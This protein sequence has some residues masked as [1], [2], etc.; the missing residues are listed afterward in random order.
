M[1]VILTG[2]PNFLIGDMYFKILT[3]LT[4]SL[5]SQSSTE[6]HR[7]N[8]FLWSVPRSVNGILPG[9]QNP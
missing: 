9:P 3:V 1:I 4:C 8:T 7:M 2:Y 6:I 5:Y